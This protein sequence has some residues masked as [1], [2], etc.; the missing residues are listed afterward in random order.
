MLVRLCSRSFKLGFSMYQLDFKKVEEPKNKLP[1]F[2]ESWRKQGN[3]RKTSISASL[4]LLKPLTV[5]ITENC[6]KFLK[7]W[8]YQTTLPVSC[9]TRMCVAAA[10]AAKSLQSYPTLCDPVDSSPPGAPVPGILQARTLDWVAISFSNAWK[11]KVKVKSLSH[12]QL[13]ATPW[14][15]AYQGPP[16]TGFSRQEYWSGLP[17]PSPYMEQ[18]TG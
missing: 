3:S 17:V 12:V 5:W 8:E 16:A 18:P 9:K 6:G 2:L 11:G 4:T 10:A 14:T 1:T 15:A 7:K 13:L